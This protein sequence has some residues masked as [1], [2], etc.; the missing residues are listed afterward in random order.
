MEF[1][2]SWVPNSEVLGEGMEQAQRENVTT[3]PQA[4]RQDRPGAGFRWRFR[5]DRILAYFFF[6]SKRC[7]LGI[8]W[9]KSIG[10]PF[11]AVGFA[12]ATSEGF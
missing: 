10:F 11:V 12:L 2:S 1:D 7:S 6:S 5:T 4:D 3:P 9:K 8:P